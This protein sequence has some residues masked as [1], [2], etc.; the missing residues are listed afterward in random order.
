MKMKGVMWRRGENADGENCTEHHTGAGC[1]RLHSKCSTELIT[2]FEMISLILSRLR[3]V[4]LSSRFCYYAVSVINCRV[5]SKLCV[6]RLKRV[7]RDL[8]FSAFL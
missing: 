6:L 8:M 5:P 4:V 2:S 3:V 7:S 1:T